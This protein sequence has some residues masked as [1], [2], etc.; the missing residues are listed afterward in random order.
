MMMHLKKILTEAK[1]NTSPNNRISQLLR[2]IIK[3]EQYDAHNN[4]SYQVNKNE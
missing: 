2:R 4:T 1:I 3:K